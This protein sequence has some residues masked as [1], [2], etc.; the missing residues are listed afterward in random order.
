MDDGT[1][2]C[3]DE[4]CVRQ[5]QHEVR[6]GLRRWQWRQAAAQRKDMRGV[7]NGVDRVATLL[8]LRASS[9]DDY[10]KGVLRGI[11]SGAIWTRD[12]LA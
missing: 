5:W 8:L 12:R 6:D 9:T 3:L 2:L 10:Q 11:I 4:V 1:A 7:E